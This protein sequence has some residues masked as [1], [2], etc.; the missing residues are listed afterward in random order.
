[1]YYEI[2][3]LTDKPDI[4]ETAAQWFHEKWGISYEA[5]LESMQESLSGQTAVPEWYLALEQEKIIGGMGVIEN[6]F[7]DRKDLTP[8]VC[9]VY[10][11]ENRRCQGIAG[12]LLNY[13]CADMKE[14]GIDTLYLVTDH[15][16]FYERYGWE[17]F[18]MVQGDD[19]PELSRMYIHKTKSGSS[20]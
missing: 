15:T 4:L 3:R 18:C 12:A 2:I 16:S 8:N 11:E 10:T 9:A 5:Y 13:V 14:K 20:L 6:D 1:M 17:F 7:H 19:E